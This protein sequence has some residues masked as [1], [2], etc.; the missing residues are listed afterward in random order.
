MV[1]VETHIF[2]A[3]VKEHMTDDEYSEFLDYLLE[4]PK[5]GKVIQGAGGLRKIRWMGR[6]KG[7]RGGSR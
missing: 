4:N 1:I 7:K 2:I 6:G 5:A 3:L